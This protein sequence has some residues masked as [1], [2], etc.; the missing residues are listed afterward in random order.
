MRK[1]I[2]S[3]NFLHIYT[4]TPTHNHHT[5]IVYVKITAV[6]MHSGFS[7]VVPY[8]VV[9]FNSNSV[10]LANNNWI[11]LLCFKRPIRGSIR[12]PNNEW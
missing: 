5:Q 12:G 10:T 3:C 4:L 7:D 2:L 9:I 8:L 11:R 6:K 1:L